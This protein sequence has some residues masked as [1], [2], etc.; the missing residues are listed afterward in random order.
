MASQKGT[1]SFTRLKSVP[2]AR[3]VREQ[4]ELAIR[5]G[6][7]K[8]GDK[9]PPERELTETFGVSRVS[10]REALRS[11]E[12]RNLVKIRH[13]AGTVVTDPA[14]RATRDLAHWL[15]LHRHETLDL[16]MVRG[17]LDEL[18]AT[19]AAERGDPAALA[20]VRSSAEDFAK[21]ASDQTIPLDRVIDL[22]VAFHEAIA[23]ATGSRL[24]ADLL[25]DLHEQLEESR[26]ASFAPAGR[27]ERS[28]QEHVAIVEAIERGDAEGA[29]VA[30]AAH[31]ESVRELL[32]EDPAAL[33][34]DGAQ[35]AS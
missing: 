22:D 33:G 5:A 4:L 8:P 24:L 1:Q 23:D 17:A 32:T 9:L 27:R 28:S 7:F 12:A 26:R 3:Q 35:A 10:V 20:A 29:R 11:L 2:R 30:V 16:L 14:E 15:Q 13:G 6:E 21:V 25:H 31:I 19:T 18:A 34:D